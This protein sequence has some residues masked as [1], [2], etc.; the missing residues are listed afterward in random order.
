[1]TKKPSPAQVKYLNYQYL[2]SKTV[3]DPTAYLARSATRSARVRRKLDCLIDLSYGNS[4]GQILDIFPAPGKNAPVHIFIHGGYWRAVAV[5]KL[6]YSHL[7]APLVK[8]GA[9]VV[10]LDYDLCPSVRITDIVEQVRCALVWIYKNVAKYNGDRKRIFVSGHS[11]GG[12]LAAML[13][14]TDWADRAGLPKS[15]IKGAVLLSGLFDIE[16][17]RHTELQA[18][19]RL[20]AREAKA[21]SPMYL[22]PVAKGPCILAVGENEPDLFHWQSLQYAARL[23]QHRIR[24]E[25]VSMP[26]DNHF[27][28]TDR[29]GN[30]R[31]PL[32]RALIAQMG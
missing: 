25:Y 11:A 2:P 27:S 30:A 5:D 4:P 29:L 8:A 13:L 24:A 7:A 10:L 28:L 6:L 21:M 18:D 23:R 9:T 26:G 15:L 1:M 22:N 14:A 3:H 19:I 32:T 17:H 16:P 31:D 20:G 12:H